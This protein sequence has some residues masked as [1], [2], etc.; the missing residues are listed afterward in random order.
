LVFHGRGF[1]SVDDSQGARLF[2]TAFTGDSIFRRS[3]LPNSSI[4][5]N[6][7][8]RPRKDPSSKV[9][10]YFTRKNMW[11]TKSRSAQHTYRGSAGDLGGVHASVLLHVLACLGQCP[12]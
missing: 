5:R 12:G 10:Q 8:L 1:N 4:H 6:S 9:L 3:S 2:A 7:S 11:N